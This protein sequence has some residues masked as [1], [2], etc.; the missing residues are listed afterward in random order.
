[1][2]GHLQPGLRMTRGEFP[3]K[4]ILLIAFALS[5][6]TRPSQCLG[7]QS[8]LY[9]GAYVRLE[10]TL[11]SRPFEGNWMTV[12]GDTA[13]IMRRD[14]T[15]ISIP[16]STVRT[17]KVQTGQRSQWAIGLALGSLVGLGAGLATDA[18]A[19]RG[20]G[21]RPACVA[22]GRLAFGLAGMAIGGLIGAAVGGNHHRPRWTTIFP[23]SPWPA[24]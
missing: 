24:P 5:L 17:I 23:T 2:I 10:T 7:Q 11:L 1:M 8:A 21:E 14:G 4:T 22:N 3:L 12:S 18:A 16:R 9:P 20:T 13:A 15:Q 6:A 19:C